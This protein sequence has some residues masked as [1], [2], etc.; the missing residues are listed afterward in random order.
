MSTG[1]IETYVRNLGA[2][3]NFAVI[4]DFLSLALLVSLACNVVLLILLLRK[5]KSLKTPS[6]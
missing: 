2:P 6:A 4:T 3:F 5:R 1:V